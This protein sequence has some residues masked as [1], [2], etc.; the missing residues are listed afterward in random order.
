MTDRLRIAVAGGGLI[1]QVEHIPNL[2]ALRDR[3]DLV[4]VSDPSATVRAALADRFG[5]AAVADA[6]ELL[7]LPLDALVIAAPDP[8]HGD[9]A[10]AAMG[11]GLH[12]F[13]EKPLCYG[14]A[15]IDALIAVRD[16]KRV[17]LQVG[18]MKRFDPSYE[19]AR[20]LVAGEADRLRYIGVEVNDPDFK[21]F[22]AHHPL[23]FGTD[24]P[25]EL[26][27]RTAARQRE[28]VAAALGFAPD[29][30][31]F[32]G[33]TA[34]Y[35]SSL[36]HDV[37]AVHGLLDAL[38]VTRRRV[39][40]AAL[41]EG[42]LGGQGTVQ[43]EGGRALWNMVHFRLPGVAEYRERITLYFEDR[44]VELVFPAPYLNHH[45]TRL[46]VRSSDG[47][48]LTEREIRTSY[49]EPFVRELVHF[50]ATVTGRAQ[51]R[52]PAEEARADQALLVAL[53]HRAAGR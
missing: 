50:H 1:A 19:A 43:L 27:E 45:P 22:T 24:V 10:I 20:D 18:Y 30:V 31:L 36:V 38:G 14:P 52:N 46:A 17:V 11:Q 42:G 53:L 44:I 4:A 26:K 28:Q 5:I 33:F 8:W 6:A 37:N 7:A 23:V 16:E 2:L 35:S 29:P 39:V 49:E 25:A 15:E 9:I 34:A 32:R 40:G 21:P 3:F 47:F 48:A 12:V 41:F 51:P 13:S